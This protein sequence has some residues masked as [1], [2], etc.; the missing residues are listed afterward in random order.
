[1]V[2]I[3]RY[4]EIN[5]TPV[6][7]DVVANTIRR[8]HMQSHNTRRLYP[9]DRGSPLLMQAEGH[10]LLRA[11]YTRTITPSHKFDQLL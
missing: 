4:C 3:L 7:E 10:P 6:T 8:F 5:I 11:V 9:K 1:M 2:S